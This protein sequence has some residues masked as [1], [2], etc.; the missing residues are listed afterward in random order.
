MTQIPEAQLKEAGI[1]LPGLNETT[2][3]VAVATRRIVG[4]AEDDVQIADAEKKAVGLKIERAPNVAKQFKRDFL[5]KNEERLSALRRR[6]P[7]PTASS[8]TGRRSRARRRR[9]SR[10]ISATPS[11]TAD[12]APVKVRFALTGKQH[13]AIASRWQLCLL[14]KPPTLQSRLS[15]FGHTP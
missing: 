9:S 3:T 5:P 8:K 2:P 14:L 7:S 4:A 10:M 6:G 1:N 11:M 12:K 15:V 13:N